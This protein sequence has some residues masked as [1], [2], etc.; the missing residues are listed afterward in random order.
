MRELIERDRPM[1][2]LEF[3]AARYS[4]PN[5]FLNSLLTRYGSFQEI[6]VNGELISPSFATVTDRSSTEDRLLFFT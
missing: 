1:I 3:N 4:D 2:V 6:A 5:G